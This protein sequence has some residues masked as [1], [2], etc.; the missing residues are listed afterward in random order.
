MELKN[1]IPALRYGATVGSI[2]VQ[3]GDIGA[4]ELATN[5]VTS[6]KINADAVTNAKIA[7]AAISLENLDTGIYPK[8]F[9]DYAGTVVWTGD[10]T[11]LAVTVGSAAA[12]DMVLASIHTYPVSTSQL[13]S[14][15]RVNPRGGSIL[16]TI[17]VANSSNDAIISYVGFKRSS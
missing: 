12:T 3:D 17:S 9:A 13:S 15:Q 7:D 2:E 6:I 10:G 5:A 4:A 11:N 16:I 8:A 1:F 14:L